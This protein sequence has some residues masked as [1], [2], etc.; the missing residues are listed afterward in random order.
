MSKKSAV[1][2]F[3]LAMAGITAAP[4]A[5]SADAPTQPQQGAEQNPSVDATKKTAETPC[6]PSK[7][8]AA[9]PCGPA[10]KKATNPCGPKNSC[11]P[12]KRQQAD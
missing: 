7:Q 6:G 10:K 11:G 1:A 12:K 2:A 3:A 5:H 8:K 4:L 9:N